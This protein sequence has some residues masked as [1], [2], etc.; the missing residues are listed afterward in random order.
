MCGIIYYKSF[1]PEMTVNDL[2]ISHYLRQRERGHEGF[3]FIGVTGNRI[4]TCRATAESGIINYLNKYPLTEIL[5]HHR[6]QTSTTN[7]IT[8]W[9]VIANNERD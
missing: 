9:K 8:T 2:V 7:T 3:G 6:L 5:F 1:N 4:I